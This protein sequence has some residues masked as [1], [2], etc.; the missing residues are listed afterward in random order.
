MERERWGGDWRER[1]GTGG[2]KQQK[3]DVV[4]MGRELVE[5]VGCGSRGVWMD[6]R[7]V[8]RVGHGSMT[9]RCDDLDGG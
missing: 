5:R 2:E 4:V 3:G 1:E 8:E 7:L 9:S 6:A